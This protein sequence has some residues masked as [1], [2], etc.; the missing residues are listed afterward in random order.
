MPLSNCAAPW[1]RRFR[2]TELPAALAVCFL[3]GGI[4]VLAQTAAPASGDP[5]GIAVF[6][7]ELRD[8]S[9]GGGIIPL[10]AND[11][12]YLS[13][14]TEEVR[15]L[16]SGSDDYLVIE[17]ADTAGEIV[18]AG[19]VQNCRGCEAAAAARLGADQSLAGVITRVN[20]TE[21]TIQIVIRDA[22][23]GEAVANH[24]TGLRLGANYAWSRGARSLVS[25]KILDTE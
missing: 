8:M 4:N 14:S 3:A 22:T 25:R 21:Y 18:A 6:D 23:T 24:F 19:G 11:R 20:R 16:L 17:T 13:N 10:D 7:F 2:R 1:S 15:G 9:A 12:N 5:I